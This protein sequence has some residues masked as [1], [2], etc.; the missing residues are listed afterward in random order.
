[1]VALLETV[2]IFVAGPF[3]PASSLS[4]FWNVQKFTRAPRWIFGV[5]F[6][7]DQRENGVREA[8]TSSCLSCVLAAQSVVDVS[9]GELNVRLRCATPVANRHGKLLVSCW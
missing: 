4:L 6:G 1:M 7:T 8:A 5:V 3:A 9:L 2:Q